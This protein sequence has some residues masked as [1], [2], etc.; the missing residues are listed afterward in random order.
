MRV[1]IDDF[2]TG[3]SSLAKLADITAD[4]VKID[5]AFITSIHER[6]RSQGILRVIESLCSALDVSVVAEGVETAEELK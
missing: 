6:P 3:F 2:G 1:S 4:E 5:R